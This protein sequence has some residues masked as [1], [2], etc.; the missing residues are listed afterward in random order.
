LFSAALSELGEDLA[1][2]AICALQWRGS[3]EVLRAASRLCGSFCPLERRVGADVLGQLGV[4]RSFP[5]ECLQTLLG[6]L[7]TERDHQ[8]QRAILVALSHLGRPEAI[9][10]AARLARH[11][12]ADV[13]HG[14]VL[15]LMGQEDRVAVGT[16]IE[17][18]RDREAHVRDWAT[19][20]LGVQIEMDTPEIRQALVERLSDED[21]DTRAEAMTGLARRG[22]RR[23]LPALREELTSDSVGTL[24]VEA[25]ALIREPHLHPLL[26][27]L[28]QWWDVDEELLREA[29]SA[30]SPPSEAT[31]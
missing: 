28:Q 8:V 9:F 16:L 19:F 24:A 18:T 5:E 22:D 4:P 13:R 12:D 10:P 27:A 7:E 11:A 23:M 14:V 15:A 20:A 17:L 30:C 2:D 21:A 26:A 25:A 6:M 3:E 29:I 1:W 31:I